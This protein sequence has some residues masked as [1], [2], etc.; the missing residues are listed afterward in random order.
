[1]PNSNC[2]FSVAKHK[3]SPVKRFRTWQLAL[4]PLLLVYLTAGNAKHAQQAAAQS[5]SQNVFLVKPFIQLGNEPKLQPAESLEVVWLSIEKDLKSAEN[6]KVEF[7]RDNS[8][9]WE[10][11]KITES[12]QLGFVS[13]QPFFRNVAKLSG[14]KPGQPF[15]YRLTR[16]GK[17]HFLSNAS[18]RKSV[19]QPFR[20][21]VAGDIGSGSSGQRKV[22]HQIA[23]KKPDFFVIP[24]DIVYDRGLVS[25]YLARFFPI[26]NADSSS[27]STGAP[28][29]RSILTLPV[30]GNHDIALT[31]TWEGVNLSQ[32][33]DALGYY[34]LWSSP[35]NGPN[36][37]INAKNTTRLGGSAA[38]QL[39]FVR[40][41]G[42]RFPAMANYSFDYGN[43][44][45]VIL[46]GNSYMDWTDKKMR[47]W[48]DDD[49]A[50]AKSATWKF[51]SFHQPGFSV[52]EAHADEQRMRLVS[53]IFEKH[54]VDIVFAGHAH[55]YQRSIPLR[56]KPDLSKLAPGPYQDAVAGSFSFDKA[57]DGKTKTTPNGIIYIV[58]GGGGANLYQEKDN[59]RM[60]PFVH[61]YVY[62]HSFTMVDVNGKTLKLSQVNSDGKVVDQFSLTK[63]LSL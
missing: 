1:V 15:S 30:I 24:G 56:F 49:L 41:A 39:N 22:A 57:F 23:L 9:Q 37:I 40:G 18:A 6:W 14:L 61:K 7:D 63:P 45:W 29:L 34:L 32:F 42:K 31:N 13:S 54:N 60:A 25:E 4:I 33:P 11:G 47:K 48:L 28:L 62:A 53:D 35:L 2:N 59:A 12:Q 5:E 10:S 3:E 20:F 43:S 19:D 21:A 17:E 27:P 46:D 36:K 51:A 16:D 55:C 52:D 58:T 26:M 38:N 8:S 50:K 44:H